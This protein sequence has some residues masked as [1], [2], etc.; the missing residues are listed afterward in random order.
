MGDEVT[1][2][3]VGTEP[4]PAR[5]R[6]TAAIAVGAAVV[7]V[8]G[9][10]TAGL[11][12]GSGKHDDD[13]G[14]KATPSAIKSSAPSMAERMHDWSDDGGS[15]TLTTLVDDLKE[16]GDDSEPP[17]LDGLRDSCSTLTAD[18]EAAQEE[19]PVPDSATNKRWALALDH[20]GNSATACTT[21]AVSGD[22]TQFD[23][24][25]SE[26]EIGIKH[27]NAV[28]KRVDKIMGT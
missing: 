9:I 18:I 20:L 25:A 22:Q 7:A 16:V 17:D 2:Q 12:I 21:G 11:L 8:A 19:D 5:K 13:K 23:L 3:S 4:L 14:A 24:M 6:K 15:E 28:N 10:T 26:M 27:L 1:Q